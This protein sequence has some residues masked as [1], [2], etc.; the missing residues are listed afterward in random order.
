MMRA[1]V[2]MEMNQLDKDLLICFLCIFILLISF[3][4]ACVIHKKQDTVS[5][6]HGWPVAMCIDD[7]EEQDIEAAIMGTSS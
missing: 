7:T 3:K 5:P 2:L 4:M 1:R 6:D